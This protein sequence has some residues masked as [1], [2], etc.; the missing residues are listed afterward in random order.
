MYP[1]TWN[2][3]KCGQS[4]WTLQFSGRLGQWFL[5][6]GNTVGEPCDCFCSLP[7]EYIGTRKPGGASW[8]PWSCRNGARNPGGPKCK[9]GEQPEGGGPR[10]SEGLLGVFCW[11]TIRTCMWGNHP[12]HGRAPPENTTT[13][14]EQR[15]IFRVQK[16]KNNLCSH[17]PQ[18]TFW[19]RT[20]HHRIQKGVASAGGQDYL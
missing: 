7:R 16:A 8:S 12:M 2:K 9:R 4:V 13:R 6:W 14:E 5:R 18:Q 3:W 19:S 20:G 1:L 10:A 15:T 11:V 17:Q